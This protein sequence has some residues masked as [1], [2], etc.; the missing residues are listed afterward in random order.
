MSAI[1]SK[2]TKPEQCIQRVL[3]KL[4][5]AFLNNYEQLVGSPDFVLPEFKCCIF[6]NGCYWHKHESCNLYRPPKSRI[7]FWEEKLEQNRK[8]DFRTHRKLIDEGW[9]VIVVWECA[10]KGRERLEGTELVDRLEL[11][12]H[13]K[14]KPNRALHLR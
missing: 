1:R 4:G 7:H 3:S 8:R 6:V 14:P 2:N 5:Y 12:I 9:R 11:L 13:I 10:V